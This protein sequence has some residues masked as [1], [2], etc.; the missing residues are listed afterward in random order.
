MSVANEEPELPMILAAF[1]RQV[2]V[3][4]KKAP[5]SCGASGAWFA[6]IKVDIR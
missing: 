4:K 6:L 5:Q 1:F 3:I 2:P